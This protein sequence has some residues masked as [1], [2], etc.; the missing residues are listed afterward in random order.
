LT[1]RRR[2]GRF[3]L[4]GV[5]GFGLQQLLLHALVAYGHLHYL[6]ATALAVEGAILHNFIWHWRWTWRDRPAGTMP[7]WTRLVR[8]NGLTAVASIAGMRA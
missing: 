8:F 3:A 5:L 1:A 2:A 6:T 4:V 7:W